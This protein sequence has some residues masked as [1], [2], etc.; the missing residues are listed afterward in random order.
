M[1]KLFFSA[2]VLI[3]SIPCFA[4]EKSIKDLDFL[5]GVWE[6]EEHH[7]NGWWEK[8]TRTVSYILNDKYLKMETIA[9]S[10]EGKERAYQF[11]INYNKVNKQFE[12]VSIY[13][14]WPMKLRDIL[15]WDNSEK[16]LTVIG[17]ASVDD[18]SVRKGTLHFSDNDNYIWT[19]RNISGD[20][21]KRVIDYTE[22]GKRI[23]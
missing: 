19:G 4:Q 5:I 13:S 18:N 23:K 21:V 6:V 3:A 22:K 10:S 9:V 12:M 8:G 16:K 15:E 14:N 7:P 2:L 20:A 17:V 11:L 1:K